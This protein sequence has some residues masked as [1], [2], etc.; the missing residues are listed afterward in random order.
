MN[1]DPVPRPNLLTKDQ[2]RIGLRMLGIDELSSRDLRG[3]PGGLDPIQCGSG[4]KPSWAGWGPGKEIIMGCKCATWARTK[5]PLFTE[6]HP[7]CEN[8]VSATI[9]IYT[10]T[11]KGM[12]PCTEKDPKAVLVW[13][14]EAQPGDVIQIVVSEMDEAIYNE[15]PEY[16]GP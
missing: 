1:L 7:D 4:R 3:R 6:H 16:M 11:P 9:R 8:Y 14:E 15:I 2:K 10:V 13:L 12:A 5:P